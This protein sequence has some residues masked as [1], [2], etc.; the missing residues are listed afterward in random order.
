[1]EA[2]A[3]PDLLTPNPNLARP[4]LDGLLEDLNLMTITWANP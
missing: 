4:N 1:M 2:Q 3:R